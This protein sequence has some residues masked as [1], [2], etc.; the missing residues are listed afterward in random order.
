ML[1][2]K[3][4]YILK[5]EGR[6]AV[7]RATPSPSNVPVLKRLLIAVGQGELIPLSL[8]SGKRM[9]KIKRVVIPIR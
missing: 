5:I 6:V 1:R 8:E 4:E 7:D 2:F 3:R 9:E